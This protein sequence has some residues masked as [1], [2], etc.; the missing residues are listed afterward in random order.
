MRH[1]I[2]QSKFS[3]LSKTS[4]QNSV[5]ENSFSNLSS[6]FDAD[7]NSGNDELFSLASIISGC[8]F[9]S[10]ED[11]RFNGIA[12]SPA[13]A[14][15][16]QLVVYRIGEGDP[17]ELIADAMARGAA[18][19]LTEQVLPCPL[20]QCVVGDVEIAMAKVASELLERPDQ[21]MLTIGV[22]GSAGK[23][24]SALLISS[25]LRETSSR[26]AYQTSLGASDGIVQT[27][28]ATGLDSGVMLIHWLSEAQDA[29]CNAC[30][31]EIRGDDARHGMY[32]SV[33]F[34]MIVVTSDSESASDF[35]PSGLQCLLDQ[36]KPSGVVVASTDDAKAIRVIR[37]SGSRMVTYGFRNPADVTGTIIEQSCGMTTLMISQADTTGIMETPLCGAAMAS[38]HL[39]AIVVGM[40]VDLPMERIT[41][42]LSQLRVVPGRG[43]RISDPDHADVIIDAAGSPQ[44]AAC[45]LKTA[46]S[47]KLGGQ[48][49]CVLTISASDSQTSLAEYGHFLERFANQVVLTCEPEIKNS[50]LSRSHQVLD[51]VEECAAMRLVADQKRA[52]EWAVRQAKS[53][54]TI[55]LLGGLDQDSALEERTRIQDLK[56][57]IEKN[58][59]TADN[60]VA[61]PSTLSPRSTIQISEHR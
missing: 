32:E 35:G 27:T 26:T 3:S 28:P 36:L 59:S 38:N 51:G 25:L 61:I 30:V 10:G 37:D 42:K 5:E 60:P 55:L 34:D 53:N 50:F 18:G 20:P 47:M 57:L 13:T 23:T 4:F 6:K 56:Q 24:T 40:L 15:P 19:L 44:R 12:E 39:A 46:R 17:A 2:D 14:L 22:I 49:W 41:S 11:V 52:I 1:D 8:Q 43:E 31:I 58:R 45:A 16:G 21:Q 48:L 7:V 29:G 33:H 54:D 9:F